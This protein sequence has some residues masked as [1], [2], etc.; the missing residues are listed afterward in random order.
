MNVKS[1]RRLAAAV[2][3][4]GV[5]RVW[6]DPEMADE[7]EAAI[8]RQEIRKLI[9][10][11]AIRQLP[12]KGLS[13]GRAKV[14]ASQR[15]A[16]RRR[17]PGT[18]K[19]RKYSVV[20]RKERWMSRIRALRKRLRRLRDRRM[21]TVSNYRTLYRKAKGG[22]FRSVAEMERYITENNLRRRTFG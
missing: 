1:Q 4:I 7:V 11:G 18:K 2:L 6:I 21:I 15:K 22:E 19:G 14:R 10:E 13:R 17:G 3:G 20:T 12:E 5:N 16:G 8:T 9:S